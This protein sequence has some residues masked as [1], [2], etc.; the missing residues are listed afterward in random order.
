[1]DAVF[2]VFHRERESVKLMW[3]W[4]RA[5]GIYT[6]L[7]FLECRRKGKRVVALQYKKKNH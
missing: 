1:M 3:I 6:E 7:S 4:Q 5:F 2:I